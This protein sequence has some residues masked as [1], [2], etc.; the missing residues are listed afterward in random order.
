MSV[1]QREALEV[2]ARARS[3]PHRQVQRAKALLLAA[4]GV[5]NTRIADEVGVTVVTVRAW[6]NRFAEEG[7]AKLGEV[8]QGRGP[9]P[10]I[11]AEKVEEIVA[12]T[13]HSKPKG[14]THWSTRSMAKHAGV[15]RNTVQR[16]W[17]ARGLKPHLLDTVKI[18]TDPA[19]E[20]KLTDVVGVYLNPPQQAV[21]LCVDEKSQVQAL[22]RTQPSL[23]MKNGR[24]G[25]L[26]HDY[27]RN[28]T[29]TLFAALNVLTGVVIGQRL[30]RHRHQQF[31]TF[32]RTIDNQVPKHLA[33]HLILDN[34]ATHVCPESDVM[35]M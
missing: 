4:D 2:L 27:K 19:F 25:T 8:R 9:K 22:D 31:L 32:L 29:T 1:G 10:S 17:T 20:D 24:A 23:P 18:S 12:A 3:A 5:A 21:V 33:V 30:P 14:Q 26:T 15:S 28:G 7:L 34:Y 16:I 13:L 35:R 11:P 6:R